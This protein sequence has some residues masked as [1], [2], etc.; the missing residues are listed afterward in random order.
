MKLMGRRYAMAYGRP[1]IGFSERG[2]KLLAIAFV[3]FFFLFSLL[4]G[5]MIAESADG[6]SRRLPRPG[7]GNKKVALVIGNKD[8]QWA[9]LKNSVNDAVAISKALTELGFSVS[10]KTNVDQRE[11][12]DAIER[13]SRE[14]VDAHVSLFY[15]SGH[16]CQFRGENYLVPVGHDFQSEADLRYKAVNAGF[17]LAM[18]EQAKAR[19]NI[20][21]LDAC[22]NN[23]VKGERSGIRG[24]AVLEAPSGTFIAYATAPG[25]VASDT[26]REKNSIYTKHL[27][28]ALETKGLAIEQV[29]KIVSKGVN[30]DTNGQ[31]IPWT[32]SSLTN[33]FV[34][35]PTVVPSTQATQTASP[36]SPPQSSHDEPDDLANLRQRA[37]AGDVKAQLD[38]GMKYEWGMG[39]PRNVEQAKNFYAMAAAKGERD[40]REALYRLIP[41]TPPAARHDP[42]Q[43]EPLRKAASY[44]NRREVERLLSEG[45]DVNAKD[46]AGLTALHFAASQGGKDAAQLL[47]DR[48]ADINAKDYVGA[49][50][51]HYATRR[52]KEAAQFFLGLFA[53][54]CG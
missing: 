8:Y 10:I 23:P 31:Q 43:D 22:R 17:V 39:M 50:P 53:I 25:K 32:A 12:E 14:I 16:G 37:N 4:L 42:S 26:P 18:M 52:K 3:F 41:S 36:A 48:G 40:P 44:G 21:I 35:N 46:K 2:A 29:F 54:V 49:T 30:L 11:F 28:S 1:S 24:L 38:L 47:L 20:M 13:F 19:T 34:F 7:G 15:F 33:D 6:V 27:L 9:P 51:L 5:D 45:A